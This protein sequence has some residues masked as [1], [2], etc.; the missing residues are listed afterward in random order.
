MKKFLKYVNGQKR[1][2]DV[3]ATKMLV[4][5]ETLDIIGING[6]EFIE[7]SLLT[8]KNLVGQLV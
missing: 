3:S 1:F 4:K 6:I 7:T 2:Y 8:D 5:S